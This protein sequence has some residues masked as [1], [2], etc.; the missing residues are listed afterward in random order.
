ILRVTTRDDAE[1]ALVPETASQSIN[2]NSTRFFIDLDGALTLYGLD[3]ATLK[4]SKQGH[5]FPS[6]TTELIDPSWSAISPDLLYGLDRSGLA[7][8]CCYNVRT[9]HMSVIRDFSGDL[10]AGEF[11]KLTK[12]R[13]SDDHFSFAWR[14]DS[15]SQ[16]RY[17]VAWERKTDVMFK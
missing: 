12:S 9:G 15:Q 11:G 5:L 7:R 16:W 4:F 17:V 14:E 10:A 2:L 8:L 6:S 3:P 1:A 13:R